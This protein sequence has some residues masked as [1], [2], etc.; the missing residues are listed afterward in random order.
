MAVSETCGGGN[1]AKL[2]QSHQTGYACN[3]HTVKHRVRIGGENAV[4]RAVDHRA[5]S[6]KEDVKYLL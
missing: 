3:G 6:S 5:S 2:L 4:N 1:I